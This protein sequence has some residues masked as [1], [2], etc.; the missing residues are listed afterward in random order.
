MKAPMLE[1]SLP[2]YQMMARLGIDPAAGAVPQLSLRYA[3]AL[4]RCEACRSKK[5]CQD[6]LEC[7]PPMVNFAPDFCINADILFDLQYDQ[8]GPRRINSASTI[9]AE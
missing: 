9:S 7:A 6:W 4:E 2:I 8:V 1:Y 3:A 5:T